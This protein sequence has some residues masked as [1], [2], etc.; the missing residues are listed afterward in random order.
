[1]SRRPCLPRRCPPRCPYPDG[2]IWKVSELRTHLLHR[3]FC[4]SSSLP[5]PED[6][7]TEVRH[8]QPAPSMER[9]GHATPF[10][11]AA[12]LQR[13]VSAT[14]FVEALTA[15]MVYCADPAIPLPLHVHQRPLWSW[16][17]AAA[18][19][20]AREYRRILRCSPRVGDVCR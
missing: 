2:A 9:W 6:W 17:H 14:T 18:G 10:P 3:D 12:A 5:R 8:A 11:G 1:M 16:L 7:L 15:E 20:R 4:L 19:C 13:E